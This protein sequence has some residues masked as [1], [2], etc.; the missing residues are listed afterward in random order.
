MKFKT[1]SKQLLEEHYA[2]LKS[3]PF[4]PGLLEYMT[5][6]PVVPMVS[7]Q[8]ASPVPHSVSVYS[9]PPPVLHCY[10]LKQLHRRKPPSLGLLCAAKRNPV[11]GC[12]AAT[13]LACGGEGVQSR[14]CRAPMEF[15]LPG[16]TPR[17]T[18]TNLQKK[19]W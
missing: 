13:L 8:S 10:M 18:K 4:F 14:R 1:P 6:G 9:Y 19:M 11:K 17:S 2:D 7:V 12:A 15:G 16:Q 5:S 3:K